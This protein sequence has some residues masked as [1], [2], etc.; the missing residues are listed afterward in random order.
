LEIIVHTGVSIAHEQREQVDMIVCMTENGRLASQ[1]AKQRPKQPILACC[2][3][4]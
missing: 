4:G 3:N 2:T 1:L